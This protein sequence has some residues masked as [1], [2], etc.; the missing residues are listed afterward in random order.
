[1]ARRL[2]QF[3]L[4]QHRFVVAPKLELE[5]LNIPAHALDVGGFLEDCE[6][7]DKNRIVL[8]DIL[9]TVVAALVHKNDMVAEVVWIGQAHFLSFGFVTF[10]KAT[11]A[12]ISL[13]M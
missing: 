6:E 10:F 12:P 9:Q 7:Q 5:L 11:N 2:P 4:M 1:M 13:A 3:M 8:G